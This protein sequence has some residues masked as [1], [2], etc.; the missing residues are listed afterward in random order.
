MIN[1]GNDPAFKMDMFSQVTSV[2]NTAFRMQKQGIHKNSQKLLNTSNGSSKVQEESFLPSK[3]DINVYRNSLQPHIICEFPQCNKRPYVRLGALRNHLTKVHNVDDEYLICKG[4]LREQKG[5][6]QAPRL[7]EVCEMKQESRQPLAEIPLSRHNP[8]NLS[9]LSNMSMQRIPFDVNIEPAPYKAEV[10]S[11]EQKSF[12]KPGFTNNEAL[13]TENKIENIAKS[14]EVSNVIEELRNQPSMSQIIT[15]VKNSNPPTTNSCVSSSTLGS[16]NNYDLF[17]SKEKNCYSGIGQQPN[18]NIEYNIEFHSETIAKIP[19]EAATDL[20]SHAGTELNGHDTSKQI[21]D[22]MKTSRPI[23]PASDCGISS[24]QERTNKFEAQILETAYVDGKFISKSAATDNRIPIPNELAPF[25]SFV[26]SKVDSGIFLTPALSP[27]IAEDVQKQSF[28]NHSKMQNMNK[29]L[30]K[31]NQ[32]GNL[33]QIDHNALNRWNM[34]QQNNDLRNSHSLGIFPNTDKLYTNLHS[35]AGGFNKS[36]KQ[37]CTTRKNKE[38]EFS[39]YPAKDLNDLHDICNTD[40]Y[41]NY[42][43]T[44]GNFFRD[45]YDNYGEF[46]SNE[47]FNGMAQDHDSRCD[48]VQGIELDLIQGLNPCFLE[49][50]VVACTDINFVTKF[51]QQSSEQFQSVQFVD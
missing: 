5:H 16:Q 39:I 30:S 22:Q 37:V 32:S 20:H 25:K 41:L 15:T 43:T 51:D 40:S 2:S 11:A 23:T 3:P 6:K 4:F 12:S 19:P 46:I 9:S 1:Q 45:I 8:S 14:T 17:L 29:P 27:V 47:F 28:K 44:A 7:K 35:I 10:H 33:P 34:M 50:P 18:Q 13:C 48:M 24:D 49:N 26:T 36:M 21:N 38:D 42:A 31:G